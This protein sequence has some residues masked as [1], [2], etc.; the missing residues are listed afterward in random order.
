MGEPPAVGDRTF[1]RRPHTAGPGLRIRS[2][3]AQLFLD[4]PEQ[5]Q[6]AVD[7]VS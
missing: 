1:S 2:W 7:A 3:G 4:N 5:A 6:A